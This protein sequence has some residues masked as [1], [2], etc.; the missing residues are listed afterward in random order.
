MNPNLRDLARE[1]KDHNIKLDEKIAENLLV[2][3]S[4]HMVYALDTFTRQ[5]K[6]IGSG[7]R[8][9]NGVCVNDGVLYHAENDLSKTII[10]ETISGKEVKRLDRVVDGFVSYNGR[11]YYGNHKGVWELNSDSIVY[12]HGVWG[13]CIHDNALYCCGDEIGIECLSGDGKVTWK[14]DAHGLCSHGGEMYVSPF[15]A[16]RDWD[17]GIY[18]LAKGRMEF[19]VPGNEVIRIMCSHLGDLYYIMFHGKERFLHRLK[20]NFEYKLGGEGAGGGLCSVPK[21]LIEK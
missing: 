2:Y 1:T 16:F 3:T 9:I 18:N 4:D 5:E 10:R 13:L 21:A 15:F 11:I 20:D 14:P 19:S 8:N 17:E 7:A 6:V 12:D